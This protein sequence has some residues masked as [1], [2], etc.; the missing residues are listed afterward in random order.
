MSN[1]F[2]LG[3]VLRLR[4]MAEE[5]CPHA[6]SALDELLLDHIYEPGLVDVVSL[7]LR[8][9]EGRGDTRK[10]CGWHPGPIGRSHVDDLDRLPPAWDPCPSDCGRWDPAHLD[11]P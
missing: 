7:G 2:R 6:E 9:S 5:K 10:A 11:C 1:R 8:G 4:E 3:I